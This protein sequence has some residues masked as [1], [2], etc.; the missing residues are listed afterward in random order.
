M[1]NANGMGGIVNL[2]KHR[3]NPY[4]VRITEGWID[5]KQLYRYIGY[6][7]TRKEAQQALAAYTVDPH[8]VVKSKLTFADIWADWSENGLRDLSRQTN[9]SYK[10]AFLNLAPLHEK[11]FSEIRTAEI[12]SALDR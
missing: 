5:G 1:K 8:L 6:Y 2:G 7:P 3:R 10:A 4:A 11:Q 9:A 12:Q